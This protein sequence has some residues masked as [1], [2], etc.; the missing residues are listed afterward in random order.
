MDEDLRMFRTQVRQ[1]VKEE[2]VPH[3]GRWRDQHRPDPEAWEKAGESGLLLRDVPKEY[4]GGGGSFAHTAVVLE[5]LAQAGVP[6]GTR[7]H[8]IVAHYIHMYG[9]EEQKRNWLPRMAVGRLVGAI[10]MTEPSGGSDLQ[11]LKTTARREGD[12]YVV[13]GSKAFITNGWH[14]SIICLA[15]KTES[16]AAGPKGISLLIVE[17]KSLAGYS[18]SDPLKTVGLHGQDTCELVFKDVRVPVSNLLGS[19]EGN[20]FFQMMEQLPYERLQIGVLAITMAER[21]LAITTKYVKERK[22]F[23][24]PLSDLQNTRFKLAECKTEAHIGRVFLDDCIGRIIAGRLDAVTAAMAKYWLTDCQ[25]RIV[26]ECVQLHGGYG[27]LTEYPIGRM[28]IDC[29]MQR[30][31]GG[32]NEIMKE[33]I[34]WSI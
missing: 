10:A 26:D 9:S 30:I 2:F 15:V 21:A 20:G 12:H 13:N 5:E 11:G 18:A 4:G 1:F 7:E 3:Q 19:A 31:G 34:G 23:G 22:A 6:F 28:W 27:Y 24:K 32:T 29:R 25:N 16:S 8:S 33:M 14:A 17:S